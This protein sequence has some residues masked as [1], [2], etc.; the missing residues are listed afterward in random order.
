[1]ILITVFNVVILIALH[2][3][4]LSN[5]GKLEGLPSVV[6]IEDANKSQGEQIH[7]VNVDFSGAVQ[8]AKATNFILSV[9]GILG[10]LSFFVWLVHSIS[11]PISDI[12]NAM[13]HLA[14]GNK[15]IEMSAAKRHDEIGAIARLV[16]ILEENII[17]AGQL[18][19]E[20]DR[21]KKQAEE[22][23]KQAIIELAADFESNVGLIVSVIAFAATQFHDNA[24]I[25][26]EMADQTSCQSSAAVAATEEA[27]T[28]AKTIA[29]AAGY[30]SAS[31]E[32]INHQVEA[33]SRV[34]AE[35]VTEVKGTDS[36]VSTLFTATQEIGDV[37]KLIQGIAAQTNLL[38]LNATIEAARAGEAGRGFAVVAN[39]VKNLATQTARATEKISQ[40]IST[41]QNAS[42]DT[43]TASR[44]IGTIIDRIGETSAEILNAIQQQTVATREICNNVKQLSGGS[45]EIS[46][47]VVN[48]TNSASESRSAANEMLQASGELSERAE[49]L[50]GEIQ[51]FVTRIRQQG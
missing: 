13:R 28:N 22:D 49:H 8:K 31:I 12:T 42:N 20:R 18:S 3:A 34:T 38:A 10:S 23:K 43:V 51:T 11:K 21:I 17:K 33:S 24:K 25:L 47:R 4:L 6:G 16:F 48:V 44:T 32:T 41:I 45:I 40:K 9:I 35:A 14:D 36:I 15:M 27:S 2:A 1:L 46:N 26:L 37:I 5:L 19:K 39:E 29:S 7:Q 50:L 30:L